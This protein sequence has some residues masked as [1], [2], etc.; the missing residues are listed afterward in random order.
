[1]VCADRDRGG[2]WGWIMDKRWLSRRAAPLLWL[3]AFGATSTACGGEDD[4]AAEGASGADDEFGTGDDGVSSADDDADDDD[5]DDDDGSDGSDPSAGDDEGASAGDD[6]DDDGEPNDDDE[7]ESS[8][9]GEPECNEEDPVTLFL[10]PDDS[11]SMSSPVQAREAVLSEWNS[12]SNVPI[13][14]WEFFNYY[15]FDYPAA[16]P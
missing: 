4:G 15:S 12:L 16:E 2:C 5:D 11:N 10:S 13:R 7:G 1:M 9:T 14:P 6:G 3:A 8:S